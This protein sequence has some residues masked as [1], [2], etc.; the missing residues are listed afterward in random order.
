MRN[1]GHSTLANENKKLAISNAKGSMFVFAGIMRL[2]SGGYERDG[3]WCGAREVK[4][5]KTSGGSQHR[6]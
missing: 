6:I 5:R 3:M 1:S 2:E 4:S